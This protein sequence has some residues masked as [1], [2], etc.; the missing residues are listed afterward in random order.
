MYK[1][2]L[3]DVHDSTVLHVIDLPAIPRIKERITGEATICHR[4]LQNMGIY[5]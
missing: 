4:W 3:L 2:S 1:T 5:I